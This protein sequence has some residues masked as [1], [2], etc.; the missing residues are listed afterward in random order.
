MLWRRLALPVCAALLALALAA[1]GGGDGGDAGPTA[2]PGEAGATPT[3]TGGAGG[4][5]SDISATLSIATAA[6]AVGEEVTVEVTASG[7][8]DPGIGAWTFNVGFDPEIVSVVDC[9][10]EG[11]FVCNPELDEQTV[12]FA[13]ATAEGLTGE[14]SLGSITFRCEAAGTS[15]LD[16]VLEVLA[17]ATIGDPRTIDA[18]VEDGEITCG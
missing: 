17:D 4:N 10:S 7:A 16:I 2:T 9:P 11:T 12:R 15:P 13:G 5:P 8:T 14:V 18:P 3:L 1:C 6:G